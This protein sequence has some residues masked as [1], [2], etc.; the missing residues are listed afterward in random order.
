MKHAPNV[1][2]CWQIFVVGSK[3]FSFFFSSVLLLEIDVS[4]KKKAILDE[5]DF[6][7]A[8]DAGVEEEGEE[9]EAEEA[10]GEAEGEGED[11]E[12]DDWTH[13]CFQEK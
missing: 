8:E 5:E 11:E 12:I 3:F 2:N 9:A 13:F 7:V 1:T 10:E 6:V 4:T